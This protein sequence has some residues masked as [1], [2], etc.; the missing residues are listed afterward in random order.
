MIVTANDL[1]VHGVSRL[2][3]AIEKS[4]RAIISIRGKQKYV[5]VPIDDYEDLQE[6]RLSLAIKESAENIKDG[7]YHTDMRTFFKEVGI[8]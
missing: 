1:K 5:V 7:K 4:A 2:E 6:D 8:T 3:R